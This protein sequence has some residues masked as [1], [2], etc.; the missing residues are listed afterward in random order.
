MTLLASILLDLSTVGDL[1]IL[2]VTTQTCNS[3]VNFV[4][5]IILA[6]IQTTPRIGWATQ[7][8]I[9]QTIRL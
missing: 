7:K 5:V 4:N 3:L 9:S 2:E 8:V 1:V 6:S